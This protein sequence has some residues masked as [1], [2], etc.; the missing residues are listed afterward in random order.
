MCVLNGMQWVMRRDLNTCYT[1]EP[2]CGLIGGRPVHW[3]RIFRSC[4]FRT[5]VTSFANYPV[6]CTTAARSVSSDHA[7]LENENDLCSGLR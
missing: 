4:R 1:F 5:G 6:V 7:A 2:T 3:E